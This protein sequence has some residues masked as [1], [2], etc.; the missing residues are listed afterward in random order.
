MCFAVMLVVGAMTTLNLALAQIGRDLGA[1]QSH[2]QWIVDGYAVALSALVLPAGAL[3]DRFGRKSMMMIGLV[4]FTVA[5]A[6]GAWATQPETLIAARVVAGV[7]GALIF[8]GTLATI[9]AVLPPHRRSTGIAVWAGAAT[10]GGILGMVGAGVLVQSFWWGSVLA[11]T[12]IAAVITLTLVAVFTPNTADPDDAHLD[13]LGAL[14][15]AAAV[16]GM[17]LGVIEGPIR[18]WTELVTLGALTSGATAAAGFVAWELRCPRPLLDVRVFAHRGFAAGALAISSQF[19]M[20]F[21]LMFLAAQYFAFVLGYDQ[22]TS[23]LALTPIGALVIPG[24]LVANPLARRHGRGRV[25]AAGLAICAVGVIIMIPITASSTSYWQIFVGMVVLSAGFGL[26]M[27]PATAAI[28]GALPPAKQ[29]VASAVNDVTR[30]IGGALGV[31][32]LGSAFNGPYRSAIADSNAIPPQ[33]ADA[34]QDS[35]AAGLQAAARLGQAGAPVADAVREAFMDG[36]AVALT[37]AAAL[38]IATAI[39]IAAR[40]PKSAD[41]DL[42]AGPDVDPDR[43][44]AQPLNRT[45]AADPVSC[46]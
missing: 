24:A 20:I 15:A 10:I 34:A 5:A 21:G 33:F 22:L 39:T 44:T 42:T 13:P 1:E 46:T 38:L 28:V 12:A 29:G 43:R 45:S 18:G 36:W 32:A 14:L 7:G 25:I 40:T 2:L 31:A 23:A 37:L 35:V 11:A 8:P 16:G 27:A 17:V 19:F 30:E 4:I 9:T 26:A 41:R 6:W 3:G